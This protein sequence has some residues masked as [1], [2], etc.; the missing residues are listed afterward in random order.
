MIAF[1]A[2]ALFLAL[3]FILASW[4]IADKKKKRSPNF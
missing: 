3:G 4:G 2:S 1:L